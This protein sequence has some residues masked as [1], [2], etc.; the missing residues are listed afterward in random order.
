VSCPDCHAALTGA[1]C[2]YTTSCPGCVA[3]LDEAVAR[4][5]QPRGGERSDSRPLIALPADAVATAE[6][7]AARVLATGLEGRENYTGLSMP[8]RYAIGYIGELAMV[9]WLTAAGRRFRHR[10]STSGRSSAPE[11]VVL[12]DGLQATLDVKCSSSKRADA[13]LSRQR[14]DADFYVAARIEQPDGRLV[15]LMGWADA[16]ALSR[17]PVANYGH[18]PTRSLAFDSLRAMPELA[19][20]LDPVVSRAT[21]SGRR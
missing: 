20:A 7:W 13:M 4:C 14:L 19:A 1:W 9:S 21:Q 18:G 16:G 12:V 5:F 8:G 17:A 10:V 11:F 3:R 15:R 2:S 6:R